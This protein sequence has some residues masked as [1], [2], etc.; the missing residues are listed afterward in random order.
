M[1]LVAARHITVIRSRLG[2]VSLDITNHYAQAILETKR[3]VLDRLEIPWRESK[4][5]SGKKNQSVLA[6]LDTL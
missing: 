3:L 6:W 1:H 2:H 4:R 5:P